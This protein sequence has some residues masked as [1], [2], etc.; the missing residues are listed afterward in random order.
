[1]NSVQQI[2]ER[3]KGLRTLV[4]KTPE[5]MAEEIGV[6]TAEYYQAEAGT[7]DFAFTFLYRC[8]GALGIDVSELIS[9]KSATLT[10]CQVVRKGEGLPLEPRDGFAYYNL[11]SLKKDKLSQPYFCVAKHSYTLENSPISQLM[12]LWRVPELKL[13]IRKNHL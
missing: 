9:G 6:S 5:Q 13:A 10:T 1:M 4:G 2:A 11:A 7:L 8:A 3:I 12:T